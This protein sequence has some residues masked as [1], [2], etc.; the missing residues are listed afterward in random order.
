MTR[1][2]PS[3]RL[4]RTGLRWTLAMLS[5]LT[6][7]H[8]ASVS[9]TPAPGAQATALACPSLASAVQVDACPSDELLQTGYSGYCSDNRRMYAADHDT[10][11]RFENYRKLKNVTLWEA[12]AGG[13]WQG[14]L[15]CELPRERLQAARLASMAVSR[16]G[17]VTR[18]AC[19]YTVDGSP[20]EALTLAHRT[21]ARCTLLADPACAA[22]PAAC[23]VRCE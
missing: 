21:K 20:G 5:V 4:Q 23:R 2:S 12:G 11:S 8:A 10:C 6:T 19:A 17:S 7:V 9:E 18:V 15:S 14:Y 1:H 16:Q 3:N 13:A 22:D